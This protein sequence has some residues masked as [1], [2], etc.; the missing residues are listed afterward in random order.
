MTV[1]SG[2]APDLLT[3]PDETR[4]ALAGS[5]VAG[6]TAGG[7]FHPAPKTYLFAWKSGE[8]IVAASA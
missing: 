7:D 3:F 1:G 2:I 6:L 5:T 8:G 4:E